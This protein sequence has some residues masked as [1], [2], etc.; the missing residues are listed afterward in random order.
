MQESAQAYTHGMYLVTIPMRTTLEL[1]AMRIRK[2]GTT[3]PGNPAD[4]GKHP[5]HLFLSSEEARAASDS[6]L[7]RPE[8]EILEVERR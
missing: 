3:E 6:L 5:D 2:P 8:H 4:A 7:Y 1:E